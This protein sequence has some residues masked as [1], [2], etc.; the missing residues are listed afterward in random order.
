VHFEV[1]TR[2]NPAKGQGGGEPISVYLTLRRYEPVSD[3]KALPAVFDELA[4]IGEDLAT[5]KVLPHL[6]AP[7]RRAI[8]ADEV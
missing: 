2:S 7:I 1:K 3:L 8:A 4:E 6:V 5:A